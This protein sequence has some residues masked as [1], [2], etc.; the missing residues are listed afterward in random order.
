MRR[1]VWFGFVLGVIVSE[2]LTGLI[3]GL[4]ACSL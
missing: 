2:I 1:M 4:H 3:T